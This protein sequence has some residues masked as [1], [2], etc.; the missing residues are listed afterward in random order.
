MNII[1]R[2]IRNAR[3]QDTG[4]MKWAYGSKEFDRN[5]PTM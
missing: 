1:D 5:L 3:D 2:S 4:L